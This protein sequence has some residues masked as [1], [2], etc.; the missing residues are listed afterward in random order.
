MQFLVFLLELYERKAS[1]PGDSFKYF[2]FEN[3]ELV[4]K[5][6]FEVTPKLCCGILRRIRGIFPFF[7]RLAR[8]I[9]PTSWHN[10]RSGRWGRV[11]VLALPMLRRCGYRLDE[12]IARFLIRLKGRHSRVTPTSA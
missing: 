9:R 6:C 12:I 1:L 5:I 3:C 11:I 7:A 8:K 10:R 2:N 4:Q